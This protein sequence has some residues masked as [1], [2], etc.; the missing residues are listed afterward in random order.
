M[1]ADGINLVRWGICKN[2][3]TF[4]LSLLAMPNKKRPLNTTANFLQ[5]GFA[6]HQR[7]KLAEA[8]SIYLR[9]LQKEP[10]HFETLHLLGALCI[11]EGLYEDSLR[12][13]EI[14]IRLDGQN[15]TPFNNR[16]V[17]LQRLD[18]LEDALESF[19]NAIRLKPTYAEALFNRANTLKAL[20]RYPDAL[21][22]YDKVLLIKP[23][24]SEALNNRG[25]LLT[26]LGRFT[27]ALE[28]YE[29]SLSIN[30]NYEDALNNK[31]NL[32][33]YL[34]LFDSALTCYEGVIRINSENINALNNRGVC[35]H[36]LKRYED[37]L[38]S[39]EA[40]LINKPSFAE[41][42]FN[43]GNTL[44][45]L[46]K[47]DEAILAYKNAIQIKPEYP[48]AFNNLG[49]TLQEQGHLH[50]AVASFDIALSLNPDLAETL[51]NRGVVLREL[52]RND[53]ALK[54]YDRA[55]I[56]QP[57]YVH[58]LN[59]RGNVLQDLKQF[60]R[61]IENYRNA[62]DIQPDSAYAHYNMGNALKKLGN[63]E[64]AI[65]S[66]DAAL[67]YKPHYAEVLNNKAALLAELKQFEEALPHYENALIIKPRYAE[68]LNNKG[69][70]QFALRDFNG[71]LQSYNI[72]L[73]IKP[74][75]S[76]ALN[77]RGNALAKL[78]RLD[79]ALQSYDDALNINMRFAE[80]LHGKGNL[81]LELGKPEE[82]LDLYNRVFAIKSD[83]EFL[84]GDR[85]S[86]KMNLCDW[87]GFD[88]LLQTLTELA[89]QSLL[90]SRPFSLLSLIDQPK[91]QKL[92]AVAYSKAQHPEKRVSLNIDRPKLG[93]KICLGYFSP[94]FR[95]HAVSYL[96]VELFEKHDRD[97]F[98]IIGFSFGPRSSTW[99]GQRI[100]QSFDELIDVSNKSDK[101]IAELSQNKGIQIAIDLAGYT[102][103]G[104]P[105]I[106]SF[107]AAPL[108]VS[109]LGYMGT[110]GAPYMDYIVA[111]KVIV[112]PPSL[113][114]YTEKVIY[115]PTCYQIS[116]SKRV[117]SKRP[118]SRSELGLPEKSFVFCCL[119]NS[120]KIQPKIFEAWMRVLKFV[121][122][123]VIWLLADNP[124]AK[125]NLIRE[126][127]AH[128]VAKERLIFA[129]RI[130]YSKYL[131]QF[132][133][134]DLFLDTFPYN[135][136]TTANDALYM[137]LPVLT[138]M[139]ETMVS[140]MAASLL[141]ALDLYELITHSLDEYERQAITLAKDPQRLSYLKNQ[142]LRSKE[143]RPLFKTDLNIRHLEKAYVLIT[144]RFNSKLSPD[145]L[146]I[147]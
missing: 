81:M 13:I 22:G 93:K 83:Y 19:D 134:A 23:T 77:N 143:T 30:P 92:A 31:G 129:N 105:S 15:P 59:N 57:K 55:L 104:R 128:N 140:R 117:I 37:A 87:Y 123:S 78:G 100:N 60:H 43:R 94:D 96:L 146:E 34:E 121:D 62:L 111:D 144:E 56:I 90:V 50:E 47:F 75:F 27:E 73:S 132:K 74:K 136:G 45:E 109:Y 142:L 65:K 141:T 71:A 5:Q 64:E 70:T 88:V 126:A 49:L 42:W 36:S 124:K 138:L 80:A 139:G 53:E 127:A 85:L 95:E 125:A 120:Y 1:F 135:A 6:L 32:L 66:Y 82:A 118:L 145:H 51:N 108:Q 41:A 52:G 133:F 8:K 79:E 67:F 103:N 72:A 76:E 2:Q 86:L 114:D 63:F 48:Q 137:G 115:L 84:L 17:A 61:A 7:N 33:Q 107:R 24:Y 147:R 113:P 10:E 40:A 20:K 9:I 101:E 26:R 39:Y 38:R 18:H 16:G 102:K 12:F 29:K 106:F 122:G 89:A 131:A 11:Q 97:Q 4:T 3:S 91:L 35:L 21:E 68:A 119:N 46:K 112:P 54:N 28:S 69:N 58:A 14:T 25:E 99:F 130:E 98:E 44:K 116:D 110:L